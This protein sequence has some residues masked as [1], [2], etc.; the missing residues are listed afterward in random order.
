MVKELNDASVLRAGRAEV[1]RVSHL[2]FTEQRRRD[3][4]STESNSKLRLTARPCGQPC[5]E[6]MNL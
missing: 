3:W 4:I 6:N 5:H 1:G 2:G